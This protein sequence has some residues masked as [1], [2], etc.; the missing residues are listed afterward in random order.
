MTGLFRRDRLP[1]PDRYYVAQGLKLLGQGAD[2]KAL[3]PFHPDR[4]PSLSV[5]VQS[6]NFHCFAC[7]AGGDLVKFHMDRNG[8]SFPEAAKDLGA[9]D[10]VNGASLTSAEAV[11]ARQRWEQ[12]QVEAAKRRDEETASAYERAAALALKVINAA[13]RCGADHP[14]LIAKGIKSPPSTLREMDAE[15]AIAML[16]YHPKANDE[17]LN[18][19]LVVVPIRVGNA[20][21]SVEF[22]DEA[23][24]K[25]AIWRGNKKGGHWITRSLPNGDGSGVTM[26]LGEGMATVTSSSQA[27]GHIGVAALS[28]N[29]LGRVAQM[30][31][32]KYPKAKLI[33]LADRGIGESSARTAAQEVAGLIA[34]PAERDGVKDFND[35]MLATGAEAVRLAIEAAQLVSDGW[36]KAHD[37]HALAKDSASEI[38]TVDASKQ[39]QDGKVVYQRLSEIEAKPISWL[40][41]GRIARGKPTMIAGHPGLG[42]SQTTASLAAVVTTGGRWPVDRSTCPLGNVLFL[43]AEDD[44]AD[45]IRPRLEAAGADV[46][47]V[48][49]LK[50]V[51]DRYDANGEEVHRS[52]NLKGDIR[53]LEEAIAEI[54]DV[55]L[56]VIDPVSAYLGSTESHNNAE[57]RALLAPLSEM[58]ARQSVA[59]VLVSHLNKGGSGGEALMRV[60]GSLAFVA[61]ARAAFIV[62]KD[63]ED[64][65]RRLFIPAKNNIAKDQGGLAFRIA[66]ATLANGIETSLVM[67]D[68]EPVNNV[69]ADEV[70]M[71]PTDPEQRSAM[72]E[73]KTFLQGLLADAPLSAK[74]VLSNARDAGHADKTI[75]RASKSLGIDPR[76]D[77]LRGGWMWALPAKM[78]KHAEDAQA[79]TVGTFGGSGHLQGDSGSDGVEF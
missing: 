1:D 29:N 21:S 44:P 64:E 51:V 75:R 22:I 47:R 40:W 34:V 65:A 79:K 38:T 71:I 62:A 70:L 4:N 60:T 10:G 39:R 66:P 46:S 17:P 25:S 3:C 43:S 63:P 13:R 36:R 72:E 23:G 8:F 45:T 48:H 24:R 7:G 37:A 74:E 26:L 15:Q 73:A 50:A 49:I 69:T 41:P 30:L 20:F 9:W 78:A 35:L 54:G 53:R 67:W 32:E 18:G 27:T 6:G 16:G 11:A 19:R 5:N 52:F 59:V 31:R 58:A 28:H 33:L 55:A 77:G 12:E 56:V 68:A 2:R 14:Y 57:V 42:K 76:K 61:A